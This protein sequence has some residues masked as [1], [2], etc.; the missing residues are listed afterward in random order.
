MQIQFRPYSLVASLT[1]TDPSSIALNDTA[2]NPIECN[3]ISVEASTAGVARGQFFR[4]GIDVGASTPLANYHDTSTIVGTT[5]GVV[6]GYAPV[7]KGVVE[8]LLSDHDRT[9]TVELQQNEN[10]TGTYFI[11]YGQIQNGNPARDNIR[12][13]GN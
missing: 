10:G 1:T 11:T 2:G 7:N 12:P 3:F 9:S 5:S 6:G 8:L 13:T 4:V